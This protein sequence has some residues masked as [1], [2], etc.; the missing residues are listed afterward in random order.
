MPVMYAQVPVLSLLPSLDGSKQ[1]TQI[2]AE[3][4]VNRAM[5]INV[6]PDCEAL[7]R[8]AANICRRDQAIS[9]ITYTGCIVLKINMRLSC[10]SSGEADST[11]HN[12]TK[13]VWQCVLLTSAIED[14][15]STLSA[16]NQLI[17][18]TCG[19]LNLSTLNELISPQPLGPTQQSLLSPYLTFHMH[20]MSTYYELNSEINIL[21]PLPPNIQ[22][23][24]MFD[25][26]DM[27][28][29]SCGLPTSK[30]KKLFGRLVPDSNRVLRSDTDFLDSMR[31]F[32]T[33]AVEIAEVAL[34][35]YLGYR[36]DPFLSTAAKLTALRDNLARIGYYNKDLWHEL[37]TTATSC[38]RL[39]P[40]VAKSR[41]LM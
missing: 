35:L 9:Q 21:H 16:A 24:M 25:S 38:F 4:K 31:I 30:V 33:V 23:S 8:M 17:L 34:Q 3:H 39:S 1:N 5:L 7:L 40:T 26:D 19:I 36:E 13:R 10:L 15:Q 32:F 27:T 37:V 41:S 6:A 29:P 11:K 2:P 18:S 22:S 12:P 14:P 20:V 28:A